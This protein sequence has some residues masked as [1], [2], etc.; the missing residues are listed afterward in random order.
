ML[1]VDEHTGG[2]REFHF[3]DGLGAIFQLTES[4]RNAN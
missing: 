2:F 4:L 1:G 3:G